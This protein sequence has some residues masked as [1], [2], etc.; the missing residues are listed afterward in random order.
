MC[1]NFT[2]DK[3]EERKNQKYEKG[4]FIRDQVKKIFFLV[5]I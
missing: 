3:K 1:W 5:N 2:F 4:I